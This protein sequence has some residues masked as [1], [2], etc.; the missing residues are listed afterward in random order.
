[1]NEFNIL[2]PTPEGNRNTDDM[3]L[4]G[5][6][7]REA[8]LDAV[9]GGK[10]LVT[11]NGDSSG[12]LWEKLWRWEEAEGYQSKVCASGCFCDWYTYQDATDFVAVLQQDIAKF[13]FSGINK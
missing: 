3:G 4:P 6:Y 9:H 12:A 8:L 5:S 1:M 11:W 13:I 10:I 2:F 7:T